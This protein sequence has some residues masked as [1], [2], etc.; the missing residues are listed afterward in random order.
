MLQTVRD[1][2]YELRALIEHRTEVFEKGAIERSEGGES[3]RRGRERKGTH[4]L[5]MFHSVK[6]SM[7]VELALITV[8]ERGVGKKE[9]GSCP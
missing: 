3:Y 2:P 5:H 7:H 1:I 6:S 8:T 4:N 9:K